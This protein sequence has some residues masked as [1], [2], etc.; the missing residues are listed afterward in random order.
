MAKTASPTASN[1][2]ESSKSRTPALAA[3]G[4]K[5]KPEGKARPGA[6]KRRRTG[7]GIETRPVLEPNAAGIDI[8]AREVYVAV[9]PDRDEQPVRVFDTFTADLQELANWLKACGITT[10]AM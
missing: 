8:G 5:G 4:K 3:A 6:R 9:P 10:V 7:A 1:Q 2:R